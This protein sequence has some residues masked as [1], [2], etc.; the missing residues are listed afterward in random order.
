MDGRMWKNVK[1]KS[2]V[3]NL[4][5]ITSFEELEK[6]LKYIQNNLTCYLV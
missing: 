6:V 2:V 1:D 4:K 3:K 5:A